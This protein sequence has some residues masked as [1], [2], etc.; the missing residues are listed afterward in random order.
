METTGAVI[1]QLGL[2]VISLMA[3]EIDKTEANNK[4][5]KESNHQ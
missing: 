2:L 4:Q 1:G 3:V 5:V